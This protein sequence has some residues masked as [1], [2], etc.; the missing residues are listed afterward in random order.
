[1]SDEDQVEIKVDTIDESS[2]TELSDSAVWL[3]SSVKFEIDHENET[4]NKLEEMVDPLK[5]GHSNFVKEEI[6]DFEIKKEGNV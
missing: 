4:E 6:H 5:G 1:M 3:L 2:N